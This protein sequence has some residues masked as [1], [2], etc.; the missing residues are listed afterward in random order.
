MTTSS[1]MIS[2]SLSN[3][4]NELL[5]S[6]VCLVNQV[7]YVGE[8]SPVKLGWKAETVLGLHIWYADNKLS[9]K[10]LDVEIPMNHLR[11]IWH[12]DNKLSLKWLD[13]EIPMDHLIIF[14]NPGT[15]RWLVSRRINSL[16]WPFNAQNSGRVWD[17]LRQVVKEQTPEPWVRREVLV[18]AHL[19]SGPPHPPRPVPGFRMRPHI[20]PT[21][22]STHTGQVIL[23]P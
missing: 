4:R 15:G 14:D 22:P 9:L 21:L 7:Q 5:I 20:L 1:W 8:G 18:G 17:D 13:V 11:S 16:K 12:A 6:L 3:L 2:L 10:R 19:D 23:W